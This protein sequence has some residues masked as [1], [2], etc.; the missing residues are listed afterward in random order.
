MRQ[1][2]YV[3]LVLFMLSFYCFALNKKRKLYFKACSYFVIFIFAFFPGDV[4]LF[5]G[6]VLNS[7]FYIITMAGIEFAD[8]F[9]KILKIKRK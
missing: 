9:Y 5:K 1:F 7:R 6:L 4:I 2:V 3:L 8:T